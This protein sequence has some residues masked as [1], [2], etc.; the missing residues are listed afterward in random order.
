M[1]SLILREN[2]IKELPSSIGELVRLTALDVSHNQLERLP[3]EIVNCSQLAHLQLQHNELTELPQMI[4]EIKSL[5]RLGL[6]YNKL[7]VL[8]DSLCQCT[9]LSE[10]GLESNIMTS[11]PEQLFG[12]VTKMSTIQL[13]RNNFAG[14][15]I[16][17][18]AHLKCVNSLLIEHN[19]ITKVPLGIFS[20]AQD[21]VSL[22]LMICIRAETDISLYYPDI[23][24]LT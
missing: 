16:V 24:F 9:E 21:L 18:P 8:P 12:S 7:S 14:F 4:G 22:A 15:P 17:D 13:S 10:I 23:V 3:D 1:T 5:R 20:Q 6:Q 19:Q 2:K 11:L